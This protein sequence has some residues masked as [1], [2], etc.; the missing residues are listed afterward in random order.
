MN[1]KILVAD[2]ESSV[3][4]MI[5]KALE[6]R[7]FSV[8]AAS[9]GDRALQMAGK[10]DYAL[11][12]LDV[13]MPGMDGMEVL[14]RLRHSQATRLVPVILVTGMGSTDE[15]IEGLAQG[16]DDYVV[17]PFS[18]NELMARVDRLIKRASMELSAN[19]LTRLPGSPC[20]EETV[21]GRI[22]Q[23]K[24]FALLYLDIDRF[25]SFNDA[26]G[27]AKGD[28]MIKTCGELLTESVLTVAGDDGFA[29]HIGG[30]DFAAV[31]EPEKAADLAH[32]I[33]CLFDQAASCLYKPEDRKRGYVETLDR[34]GIMTRS[35]IVTVRIGVATTASR[36]LAH[37]AQ[38][39]EIASELKC[40]LKQKGGRLSR[41]AI[42]RRRS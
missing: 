4:K 15:K 25:K 28:Q 36:P 3:R 14:R 32:R 17:K 11:I 9:D 19:P 40:W 8:N 33:T 16:A 24:P 34:A 2:D 6:G 31:C 20:L 39:A 27:F 7:D 10:D 21:R 29:A 38:A 5:T 42:D 22:A 18:M 12:L 35:P 1:S 26:Y 30:D 37:Y 23:G 13:R 41:F